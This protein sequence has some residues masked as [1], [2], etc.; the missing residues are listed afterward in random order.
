MFNIIVSQHKIKFHILKEAGKII[1]IIIN[2]Y[3]CR[4]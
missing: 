3:H 2:S 1:K 4:Y